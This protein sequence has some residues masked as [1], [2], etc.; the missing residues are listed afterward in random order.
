ML[1][2]SEQRHYDTGISERDSLLRL[3]AAVERRTAERGYV[4]AVSRSHRKRSAAACS[5]S[6]CAPWRKAAA[7]ARHCAG[8]MVGELHRPPGG[9]SRDAARP[10][11]VASPRIAMSCTCRG[12]IRT[13]LRP[14]RRE[15]GTITPSDPGY[16]DV[17]ATPRKLATLQVISNELIADS[18]IPM[19]SQSAR[20]ASRAVAGA[21]V[22]LMAALKAAA[23]RRKFAG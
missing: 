21:G 22:R 19:S 10:V 14:G 9:R 16:T 23:R 12:L 11:S 20:D 3:Q 5:A 2:A 15:A 1:L 6:S 8:P 18:A 4:P 7:P 17:T 13:R